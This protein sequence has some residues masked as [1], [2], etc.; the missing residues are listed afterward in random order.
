MVCT[1]KKEDIKLNI[2]TTHGYFFKKIS[3][4][5]IRSME[6]WNVEGRCVTWENELSKW[7]PMVSLCSCHLGLD[8]I[9]PIRGGGEHFTPL[10]SHTAQTGC[11][12]Y[13]IQAGKVYLNSI[14]CFIDT[15]RKNKTVASPRTL[16]AWHVRAGVSMKDKTQP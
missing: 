12:F 2:I 5:C 1:I 4:Q 7:S 9:S 3:I 14:F 16:K 13:S 15:R 8:W 10:L 6:T 11:G